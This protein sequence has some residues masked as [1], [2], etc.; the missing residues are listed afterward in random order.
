MSN[1]DRI[2]PDK[3]DSLFM[4]YIITDKTFQA[5][6]INRNSVNNHEN[7]TRINAIKSRLRYI[8]LPKVGTLNE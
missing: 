2:K 7:S 1:L 8:E 3:H 5:K 4:I 6:V